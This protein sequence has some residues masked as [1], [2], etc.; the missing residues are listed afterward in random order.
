MQ[1]RDLHQVNLMMSKAFTRGRKEDGYENTHIPLC[2]HQFLEMYLEERPDGCFVIEES[3]RI[4]AASFSHVW[5]KTGWIGPLAVDP[6]KHLSGLGKRIM[7]DSIQF[8]K[9]AGCTTIG[10]ETN[11]RSNRNLGFYGKLG[12]VTSTLTADMIRQ[13]NY[14]PDDKMQVPFKVIF[15]SECSDTNQEL[16]CQLVQELTNSVTPN[17][18]FT[19]LIHSLANYNF[20][21]SV[22]FLYQSSPAAYTSF[23]TLSTSTEEE[24]YILRNIAFVAHPQIPD[25]FFKHFLT[26]LDSIAAN[27]DL[28]QLLLRIQLNNSKFFHM[29]LDLNFKIIHTDQRMTMKGYQEQTTNDAL[30]CSRWV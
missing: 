1:N 21:D 30:Y 7:Y 4:V 27:R 22:L 25:S 23:Q 14:N 8:L 11:P 26:A 13:V 2:K 24:N 16:F 28:D 3:G 18:S 5:G 20:G 10:L 29:L 12:F 9:D 6:E 15:Y 19:P 17:I